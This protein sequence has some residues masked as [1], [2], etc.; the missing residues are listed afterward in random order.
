MIALCFSAASLHTAYY[1][2][3][4][5]PEAWECKYLFRAQ[6]RSVRRPS[7]PPLWRRAR[8]LGPNAICV[9]S[10]LSGFKETWLMARAGVKARASASLS[11]AASSRPVPVN[12]RN[13]IR[14]VR[15]N[16]RMASNAIDSDTSV[17]KPSWTPCH[18]R[19]SEEWITF[20]WKLKSL[21]PVVRRWRRADDASL[22]RSER[23]TWNPCP[24]RSERQ[25]GTLLFLLGEFSPWPCPIL[26]VAHTSHVSRA[27]ST[28]RW[29]PVKWTVGPWRW[30]VVRHRPC[31]R[32]LSARYG[33]Q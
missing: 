32:E 20:T 16:V 5:A 12:P 14:R 28:V 26:M 19:L 2:S 1:T 9:R 22:P 13:E 10:S 23:P 11:P 3:S 25:S 4:R 24:A 7:V 31:L 8:T 21:M 17:W 6:L 33:G 18:N 30:T 27:F 15:S 29:A